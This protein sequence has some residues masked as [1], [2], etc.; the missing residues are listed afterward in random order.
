MVGRLIFWAL[1]IGAIFF[2]LQG[3]EYSTLDLWR[4][5]QLKRRLA[6]ETDSLARVVDSLRKEALAVQKDPAT[7]ERIA[8][9][10]YGLVKGDREILYR[11]GDP[12]D[13]TKQR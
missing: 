11:F 7:Q 8:R 4:Q 3:G 13:T 6:I 12:E 2:G 5:R 9:E 1:V 10:Q